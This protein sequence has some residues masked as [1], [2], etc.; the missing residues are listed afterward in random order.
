M[1]QRGLET[2]IGGHSGRCLHERPEVSKEKREVS[3]GGSP[4]RPGAW[5]GRAGADGHEAPWSPRTS[6][7]TARRAVR[8][9]RGALT[10]WV[11]GHFGDSRHSWFV[12]L[13]DLRVGRRGF[14]TWCLGGFEKCLGTKTQWVGSSPLPSAPPLS[15]AWW[16]FPS[17]GRRAFVSWCLGGFEKAWESRHSVSTLLRFPP[18][19]RYPPPLRFPR[20]GRIQCMPTGTKLQAPG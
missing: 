16:P 9:K 17:V 20:R 7:P 11:G 14:V 13:F 15:T 12:S 19:L 10:V 6:H 5:A 8:A 3:R 1:T 4:L 18:H 2:P